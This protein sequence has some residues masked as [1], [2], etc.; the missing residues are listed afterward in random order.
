MASPTGALN[1]HR[2]HLRFLQRFGLAP[3]LRALVVGH[4]HLACRF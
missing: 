2:N 1:P 3:N 4:Q